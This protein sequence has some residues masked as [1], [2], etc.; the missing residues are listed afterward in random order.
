MKLA[1][2]AKAF[3]KKL[4]LMSTAFVLAVSG[5]TAVVPFMVAQQASA[6]STTVTAAAPQGWASQDGHP[7]F[8]AGPTGATGN[9]SLKLSTV[10]EAKQ[11]F[12]HAA[13][14]IA[15]QD[16]NGLG[17]K[18]NVTSG[19]P[20]SYQLSLVGVTGTKGWTTLVWE[21]VY[22][23]GVNGPT[24]GFVTKSNLENGIWWSS[25][26]IDGAPNRD[27]FVSLSTIIAANPNAK[28]VAYG[29]NVGSGTPNATS[30]VDDV[31]FMG[32]V[33]NFEA[34]PPN[35]PA[36]LSIARNGAAVASGTTVGSSFMSGNTVLNFDAVS[37]AANY[38]TEVT[39]PGGTKNV[40]NGFHNTWL[41]QNGA[42]S[43]GEFGAHG[44]GVYSYR[45][46][47]RTAAGLESTWSNSVSLTYDATAPTLTSITANG[48]SI[49]IDGSTKVSA[50]DGITF[51]VTASD[52]AGF[53]YT[54]VE[55]NKN[56]AWKAAAT[57]AAST[58]L[59]TPASQYVDGAVYGLK[60]C[61]FD[62]LNNGACSQVYFSIDNQAPAAP[63]NLTW[64]ASDGTAIENGGV[65]NDASGTA[66]WSASTSTDVDH[67]I[68]RY[69][70]DIDGNYYSTHV[71]ET[72]VNGTS[73]PGTFNQGEGTHHFAVAAVDHA[74][75][76]SDWSDP[77]TVTYDVTPPTASILSLTSTQ[78]SG[79]TDGA[80][81]VLTIDGVDSAP[82]TPAANGA[83]SYT[84]NPALSVGTHHVTATAHDGAGNNFT[85]APSTITVFAVTPVTPATSDG[86]SN[87]SNGTDS[88]APAR[89]FATPAAISPVA[90]Q[91]VLG[92]ST[93]NGATNNPSG[94]QDVKGTSTEKTLAEAVGNTDGKAF[95]L[96]WYWW[97]LIVA[98][99][100][101]IVWWIVAAV[102][103]RQ[104]ES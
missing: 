11:N 55:M 86:A 16:V 102:R 22:N 5:L 21:P 42:P 101:A 36:H 68:Y 96:A 79:T 64:T 100:A 48:Q 67:Y 4:T 80:A 34:T 10:S 35:A 3:G 18:L 74:G 56:L 95:G 40:W 72:T 62:K 78:V 82:I 20:A 93:S 75:N 84:F 99:L 91:G 33:S 2:R 83:W 54:Y 51:K 60:I 6:L 69:W 63:T 41:V 8:V 45:V 52:P 59:V 57:G 27:T 43:Q 49:A 50:K 90:T 15:L 87:P 32:D 85:T 88:Q 26:A 39:Y 70:N 37:G 66:A 76:I 13:N 73:L 94:A 24:A 97:L 31:T 25:N 12:Y 1:V 81:V 92:D 23:G 9:G 65:V 71:Y 38:I 58:I 89:T 14:N 29:V 30:Y 53:G 61:T 104:T 47:A 46:K 19:V 103:N 98:A 17:Y 7:E 77:F 44:D 28:V